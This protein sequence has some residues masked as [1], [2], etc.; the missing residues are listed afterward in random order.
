MK[1]VIVGTAGHIDHGKTALVRALTGINTDRLKEEKLRGI[2]IDIGFA[3]L[4]LGQVRLGFVDVPGHE[5]FVKNMLAGAHGIDLVLLVIAADEG[6][7]PQTR[8]HFDIC[9]LLNVKSGLIALTKSDLVEAELIE[10][11]RSEIEE[12]VRGSFLEGAPIIPVSSRTGEG[13]QELKRALAEVA[14]RVE[15]KTAQAI[16]RLP[17]DRAFSIKGFGTVVTGTLIAGQISA[18]DE[19]EVLPSRLRTR[20]RNI[21]VHGKDADRAVAGQRTAINL[22]GIDVDQV[23]RGMV[24]APPGRLEPTL[25]VDAR[26]ILLQS[27]G[28]PLANRARVRFHHGTAEVMARILLLESSPTIE[29]GQ[30][31]LA[32]LRLEGPIA[33]FPGDRFIIR[34]YSPQ[35]TIGGGQIIDPMPEKHRLKDS[36]AAS[37]LRRL[38]RA[39]PVERI[40][41]FVDMAGKRAMTSAEIAARTGATDEQ[42]EAAARSL[43]GSGRVIQALTAPLILISNRAYGQLVERVMAALSDHHSREPLALGISREELR[44][45]VFGGLRPEIFRTVIARLSEEGKI[46][47]ERDLIKLSSHKP[48]LTGANLD[49]K[50]KLE[51]TLKGAGLQALT[52][53]EAARSTQIPMDLA[54]KLC[55]LLIAEGRLIR[56]ADFLFH[57]DQIED[58][59]SRLKARK[60]ISNRI[61]IAAFKEI[62]GGLTRKYAIPLLEYLDRERI[63]RRIG[64]EREIL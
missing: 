38:E 32:Q 35:I 1:H 7:M 39:D 16:S 19:L 22:Q 20:A 44:E 14:E 10:I 64:N 9:R 61:D 4:T 33:A 23:Q 62:T 54:R 59:K 56:I 50:A 15:P 30:S 8:E 34:S 5:R 11:A 2:T 36:A 3:N 41:I 24:L 55:N 46:A 25:M 49:A 27:A 31:Q 29:P 12:F 63:T 13:I 6:I 43:T 21:Q 48:D 60:S 40:A 52:L 57:S 28:K 26:L 45:R 18:G 17:I 53:E 42:I 37:Y 51:A 47:A 58:L